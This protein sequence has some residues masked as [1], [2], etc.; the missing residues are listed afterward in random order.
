VSRPWRLAAGVAALAAVAVLPFGL[1]GHQAHVV[2]Q[3]LLFGYLSTCWNILGGF[4]GLLSFGHALF[5]AVGAYTSTLLLLNLEI[6]PWIGMVAGGLLAAALGLFI[7]YLSFRWG[8]RGT[9][10][11]LVTLAFA[12]IARNVALNWPAIGGALGLYIPISS[13]DF[14]RLKFVDKA[15]YYHVVLGFLVLAL[16]VTA[17]LERSRIGHCLVAI[18]EN[19]DAAQA[20]G[21]NLLRGKLLATGL[22]AFLT[23]LGGTLYAHY[24]TFIDPHTLLNMNMAIEMTIYAIVGGVGTLW[25]PL[26]GAAVLVPLAEVIRASLGKSYA[27]IHL[28]VYGAVLMGIVLF[29]PEGL[30]GLV[31]GVLAWR[32][33]AGARLPALDPRSLGG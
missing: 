6:S 19:E 5:L 9:Y 10:F 20:L 12:E 32:A 15:G 24:V 2:I 4:T 14:W 29:A 28:V 31:R 21:I 27:G 1:T 7:G 23:A 18:R 30:M 13:N 8:I 25:G 33:G 16:A 3:I 26:L 17:W 11:A 22:S